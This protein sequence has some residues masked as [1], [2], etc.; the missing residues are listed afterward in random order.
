ML[1]CAQPQYEVQVMFPVDIQY[2][3][4]KTNTLANGI[5]CEPSETA[6]NCVTG[7]NIYITFCVREEQHDR[8]D[9]DAYNCLLGALTTLSQ[10]LAS[11][12]LLQFQEQQLPL[13]IQ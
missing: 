2:R 9:M 4:D 13:P 1:V 7:C 12:H 3:P 6:P 8:T 11:S 10:E 5:C